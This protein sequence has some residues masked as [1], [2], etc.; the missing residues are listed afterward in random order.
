MI[1]AVTV[2]LGLFCVGIFLAV[3]VGNSIRLVSGVELG[4]GLG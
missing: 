2:V 3:I 4:D 1:E